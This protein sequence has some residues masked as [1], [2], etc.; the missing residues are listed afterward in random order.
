MATLQ[1]IRNKLKAQDNK[2]S[3][4]G[5]GDGTVYPFWNLPDNSDA[6][7][8]FLQDG[9]QSNTFFWVER[10]VI[11]LPFS[12]ITGQPDAKDV[13]VRVP[14]MEMYGMADPILAEIRP[15]W[16]HSELKANASTYWKKRSYIFQGLIIEDGLTEKLESKP[17]NPIRR[18]VLGPQLFQI[19]K[20]SLLDP[21]LDDMPTDEVNG[22]DF[23][24]TKTTKGKYSDYTTS[25]WS[26]KSRPLND[27]ELA[28]IDQYGLAN[29]KDAL[30][31]QPSDLEQKII[32]EMFEAS[33]N[34]EAFDMDRWG[35]HFRPFGQGINP[36][37]TAETVTSQRPKV[38]PIRTESATTVEPVED[39]TPWVGETTTDTEES[40]GNRAEEILK[41][42]RNRPAA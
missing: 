31:K 33:V 42:I 17:E 11:N 12:G 28:A 22:I 3:N 23:R 4:Q 38:E 26:R 29:L 41:M 35:Q 8:R 36:D 6:V 14:C 40:S 7:I 2:Q 37:A 20:S 21:E 15:W 25:K 16:D 9:D 30:P 13:T 34:G 5:S 19:V 39:A 10:L 32:M 27:L 24:I 1:E 18:F